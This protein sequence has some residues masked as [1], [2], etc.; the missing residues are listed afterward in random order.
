MRLLLTSSPGASGVKLRPG[1]R[2]PAQELQHPRSG[3]RPL[4]LLTCS[5]PT[6]ASSPGPHNCRPP[7][8][9]P[10]PLVLRLLS[11]PASYSP[12]HSQQKLQL[13]G[14][15]PSCFQQRAEEWGSFGPAL[16]YWFWCSIAAQY[17]L[18][19][20]LKAVKVSEHFSTL[21]SFSFGPEKV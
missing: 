2:P 11:L 16:G 4:H 18:S 20:N 14:P 3:Q 19:P 21:S 12:S 17:K 1:P 9:S 6:G 7:S 15:A 5:G 8:S 13:R 10:S